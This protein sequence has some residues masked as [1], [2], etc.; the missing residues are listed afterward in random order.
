MFVSIPP[1][2]GN[3]RK[4]G[5]LCE[6]DY[7]RIHTLV[8]TRKI[9]LKHDPFIDEKMPVKMY[10]LL[11]IDRSEPENSYAMA[12]YSTKELAVK[13]T[14]K[15]AGYFVTSN[16]D[17]LQFG[18]KQNEWKNYQA[19]Y[20]HVYEKMCLNDDGDIYRISPCI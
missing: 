5:C 17:L 8:L 7:N 13:N 11:F 14:I 1:E 18:L 6:Y 19:L 9:V 3:L 16:G 15:K 4:F 10:A 20:D 2:L 12:L